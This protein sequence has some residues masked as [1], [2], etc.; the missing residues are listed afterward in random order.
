M[1]KIKSSK[2]YVA[3]TVFVLLTT[4]FI[5]YMYFSLEKSPTERVILIKAQVA[6]PSAS[7]K[8]SPQVTQMSLV[9]LVLPSPPAN[10]DSTLNKQDLEQN[11]RLQGNQQLKK[12]AQEY[13]IV[14]TSNTQVL[15][16]TQSMNNNIEPNK[17]QIKQ[18]LNQLI[19][20]KGIDRTLYFPDANTRQILAYM[21][22]CVGIDIGAVSDNNLTLFSHKN[23][24]HSQIVR[25]A[26]GFKTSQ[27]TALLAAY[28]P[29]QVLVRLYPKWFDERLGKE[30][31]SSLGNQALTQLSGSYA[32]RGQSL[33]LTD[34][35]LNSKATGRDWLLSQGC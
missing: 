21:H 34:V 28:A 11:K 17:F 19:A 26:N 4:L 3:A 8:L 7:S 2:R 24:A 10:N 35:N 31:A 20:L 1:D 13:Q 12:Q 32:L 18:S 30:I 16:A 25:A 33:W 29:N 22:N 14:R 23:I 15:L 27:E 5:D 9:N 6:E